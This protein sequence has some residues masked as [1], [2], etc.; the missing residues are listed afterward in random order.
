MRQGCVRQRHHVQIRLVR[1]PIGQHGLTG[2]SVLAVEAEL[3]QGHDQDHLS[4][5]KQLQ[6]HV[7]VKIHVV[8]P[9]TTGHH[10]HAN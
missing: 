9:V 10:G 5:L 7:T 3:N 8:I 4:V 6:S 2:V 1:I